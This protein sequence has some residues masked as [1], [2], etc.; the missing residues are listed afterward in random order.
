MKVNIGIYETPQW[1]ACETE[2]K[3]HA[4]VQSKGIRRLS[5]ICDELLHLG[6]NSAQIKAVLDAVA[7]YIA[8][9]LVDGY[10]IDVEEVGIFSLS[11]ASNLLENTDGSTEIEVKVDK[12]NFRS[13]PTLRKRVDKA[14]FEIKNNVLETTMPSLEKRKKM[15]NNYLMKY[16]YISILKFSK[17]VGYS[18]YQATRDLETFREEGLLKLSGKN[19][20]KVYLPA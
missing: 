10:T 18:R 5:D 6:V 11:V 8:K 13:S 19:T 9:S 17:L 4:R 16:G 2:T 7:K 12:V 3:F 15:L 14:D 20:R 1:K